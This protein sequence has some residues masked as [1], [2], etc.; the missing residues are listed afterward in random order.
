MKNRVYIFITITLSLLIQVGGYGQLFEEVYHG[1]STST[2]QKTMKSH[3]AFLSEENFFPSTSAR[4]LKA[5]H[6]NNTEQLLCANKLK[7]VFEKIGL[8]EINEI[9]NKKN[10][11]E[12]DKE[13]Y[14]PNKNYPTIFLKKYGKKWL[15]SEET[16]SIV[17]VL[18]NELFHMDDEDE[19]TILEIPED[20]TQTIVLDTII[21]ANL[22][23]PYRTII[24]LFKYT[25]KKNY[26]PE[27]SAKALH[28][29]H[30]T[31]E[32]KIIRVQQL[33]QIFDAKGIRID[34]NE[35]P[36]FPNYRDTISGG[37]AYKF[38][39]T[40][41]LSEFY[42]E[43]IDTTWMLSNE[44]VNKIEP[45]Y[46]K[47]YVLGAEKLSDFASLMQN[48]YAEKL[49]FEIDD[50]IWRNIG[51]TLVII[52]LIAGSFISHY[53]LRLIGF[54]AFIKHPEKKPLFNK[55]SVPL[56]V[57][58]T[59]YIFIKISPS[60]GF[61]T[62]FLINIT[63]IGNILK[64]IFFTTFFFRLVDFIVALGKETY[65]TKSTYKKGFI[66]FVGMFLKAG[67]L[68]IGLLMILDNLG[69]DIL[70]ALKGLS[71]I[72]LALAL[73]AQD[74]VK[75]F[76]GSL[77]IFLDRPFQI[78]DWV[79]TND[80]SGDVETI[81]LR[82]TKIRTYDNSLI[83]IPNA[84]LTDSTLNNMGARHYR[85]FKTYLRV[86]YDTPIENIEGFLEEIRS[87]ISEHENTNNDV[88]RIYLNDYDQFGLK[89]LFD[90]FLDV[91]NYSHELETR[92]KIMAHTIKV[93]Q[94]HKVYFA[95]PFEPDERMITPEK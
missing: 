43:K 33:K 65:L 80:I 4:T 85:R 84:N 61:H 8:P 39:I 86:K 78:G 18:H 3:L 81:G 2:P 73:A 48:K 88:L 91:E 38:T 32:E 36:D 45:L 67:I 9:P 25:E 24:T 40:Y 46:R 19:P 31:E 58:L 17:S 76:F 49:P 79:K 66:P 34:P 57:Y 50:D 16:V 93:A 20:T 94:K 87:Y 15:Y 60:L 69:L 63:K 71:V 42:L 52:A 41:K 29:P 21:E 83:S 27:V 14:T 89:I 72:G 82:T 56:S 44:S 64:I 59:L 68:L 53:L 11:Q 51:I 7:E 12:G 5:D 92:G 74:T 1:F 54:I 6:L 47:T 95:I 37:P 22:T 26:H 62:D 55:L 13:I 10:Y 28:A 70:D 90:V 75:N 30:L 77:M 35:I 23:S